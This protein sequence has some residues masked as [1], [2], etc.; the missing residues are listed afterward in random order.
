Y[1]R[2]WL[3]VEPSN[4]SAVRS[5]EKVGFQRLPGSLWAPEMEME[6]RLEPA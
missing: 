2:V 5:Y 1:Q 3:S 6:V 4:R